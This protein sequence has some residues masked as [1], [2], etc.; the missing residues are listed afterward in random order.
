LAARLLAEETKESVGP[1]YDLNIDLVKRYADH[2][3]HY[4]RWAAIQNLCYHDIE[5]GRP[6][7]IKSLE[8]PHP[9]VRDA[10]R[11]ALAFISAA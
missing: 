3:Y 4:V 10:A 9:Q 6:F 7:L 2:E 5:M 8:D 1:A 11:R